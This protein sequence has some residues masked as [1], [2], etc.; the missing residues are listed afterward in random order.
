MK[1]AARVAIALLFG[2]VAAFQWRES[3]D[4]IHTVRSLETE[5]SIRLLPFTNSVSDS[6]GWA[7]REPG[8]DKNRASLWPGDELLTVSGKPFRGLSDYL[9]EQRRVLHARHDGFTTTRF[10]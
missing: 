8:N 1:S 4:T 3:L 9:R 2:L 7:T 10:R 5:I 6:I